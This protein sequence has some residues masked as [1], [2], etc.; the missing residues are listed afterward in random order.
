[1]NGFISKP[2]MPADLLEAAHRVLKTRR[3]KSLDQA[4]G[5]PPITE[6][7]G[8]V[9]DEA[10]VLGRLMGDEGLLKVVLK[11]FL[12]DFPIRAQTLIEAID[13]IDASA[14]DDQLHSLKG[15]ASNVGAERLRNLLLRMESSARS[16]DLESLMFPRQKLIAMFN[17]FKDLVGQK[18]GLHLSVAER[19]AE[20][21]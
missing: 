1:M 3:M 6:E 20:I 12:D 5:T 2:F 7:P 14:I 11:A 19:T 18:V 13:R 17:E 16:G 15:A 21:A 9:F 4:Q 10:G 8:D